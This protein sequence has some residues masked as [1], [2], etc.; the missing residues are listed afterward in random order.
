MTPFSL[1]ILRDGFIR[2][3]GPV[4]TFGARSPSGRAGPTHTGPKWDPPPTD[5][6]TAS[7]S[8]EILR[9]GFIRPPGPVPTFGA[10]TPSGR[11]GPTHTGP[12][13]GTPPTDPQTAS[14]SLEILRD[15]F[16][17]SQDLVA[18]VGARYVMSRPGRPRPAHNRSATNGPPNDTICTSNFEGRFHTTPAPR[19]QCRGPIRHVPAVPTPGPAP[20]RPATN[21]PPN[22]I[23]FT[24]NFEGWI[25]TNP[26][27]R[28]HRRGSIRH[29]PAVPTHAPPLIGQPSMDPQTA[30]F[31][32]EI[33]RDGFIPT[34][35]PVA[36]VGFRSAMSRPVRPRP[37]QNRTCHQRT[38]KRN[39]FHFKI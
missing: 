8:L 32:L 5:P 11:A 13:W 2:P 23:N 10:R 26:V 17:P 33:L 6:Q 29:V 24:L 38:P 18:T 4:A 25:H 22:G 37:A 12:K 1:E 35:D 15:G 14:F 28:C 30:P 34:R 20:N 27:P 19:C 39:H 36:T 3:P 7:F 9:D 21:G 31:S 16:I